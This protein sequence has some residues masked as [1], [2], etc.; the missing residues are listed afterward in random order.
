MDRRTDGIPSF[1]FK[2]VEIKIS[3]LLFA[4]VKNTEI[5]I[6]IDCNLFKNLDKRDVHLRNT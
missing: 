5:P 4:V 2:S 1:F 3:L 6:I